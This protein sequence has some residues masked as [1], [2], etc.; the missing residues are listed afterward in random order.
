MKPNGQ[1]PNH[2][3]CGRNLRV[4]FSS[5]AGL[6]CFKPQLDQEGGVNTV[7]F[8]QLLPSIVRLFRHLSPLCASLRSRHA[9]QRCPTLRSG[10]PADSCVRI[11]AFDGATLP[12]VNPTSSASRL[13]HRRIPSWTSRRRRSHAHLACRPSAARRRLETMIHSQLKRAAKDGVTTETR[14]AR[15]GR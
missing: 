3:D 14:F 9:D 1:A 12:P 15:S 11:F 4:R 10:A 2:R 13:S 6:F 7:I 8:C 5:D